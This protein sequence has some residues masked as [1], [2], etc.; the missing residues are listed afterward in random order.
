MCG[1]VS[2]VQ[3]SRAVIDLWQYLEAPAF[4]VFIHLLFDVSRACVEGVAARPQ[5]VSLIVCL[6]EQFLGVAETS[7]TFLTV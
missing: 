6:T 4:T 2:H 3:Q 5:R 7:V 1:K